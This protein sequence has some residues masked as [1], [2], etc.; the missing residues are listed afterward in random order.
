MR[1]ELIHPMVVHFP[2]VFVISLFVLDG[3]A[4]LTGRSI[5]A[6]SAFGRASLALACAAGVF[7]IIAY[8]FGDQ[9]SD[10]AMASGRAPKDLLAAHEAFGTFASLA[11]AGWVVV[12]AGLWWWSV[13]L[14]GGARFIVPAVDG[15]LVLAVVVTAWYGGQLVYDHG[16]GVILTRVG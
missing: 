13:P 4:S 7:A 10:I 1:L 6:G 3:Y 14:G 15:L 2:I 11:I 5:A 9:A 8:V 12:R 16:V